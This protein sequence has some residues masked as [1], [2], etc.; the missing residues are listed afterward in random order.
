MNNIVAVVVYSRAKNI[1]S[2]IKC[3]AKCNQKDAE[4]VVIQNTDARVRPDDIRTI[5]EVNNIKY[6][7]RENIGMD[8]GA[9]RDVCRNKIE[10]FPEF[11]KLIWVTDDVLPMDKNFVHAFTNFDGVACLEISNLIQPHIRTSGFCINRDIA[12]RLTFGELITKEDCYQFEHRSNNTFMFQVQKMGYEIKQIAPLQTAP[13]WDTGHRFFLNRMQEHTREFMDIDSGLVTVICPIFDSYPYIIHSLQAQTYKNWELILVHDG[14]NSTGLKTIVEKIGEKRVKYSERKERVGNWGH[15]I[16]SE[17]IQK[18]TKG[19]VMVTNPDN[20]H[21]PTYLEKMLK[22]FSHE[23]IKA[24]YCSQMVHSYTEWK[25]IECRLQLG[26]LDCGG[27]V[28]KSE[29]AKEVGW[30][31][32]ENHSSDWTFFEDVIKKH[33]HNSFAKVEGCL[34]IHN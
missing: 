29:V 16:R 6:F 23:N 25:I 28:M 33:G 15:K 22:G 5:C 7:E 27:V 1:Q 30:N 10:G 17:E 19:Y 9:F 18:L 20:Y 4:L 21:V 32:V 12:N 24:T 8:I 13:L 14:K 26:F 31:D 11:D 2:W 3:W 34:L